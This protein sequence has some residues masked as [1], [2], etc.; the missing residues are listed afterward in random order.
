MPSLFLSIRE[1]WLTPWVLTVAS[2]IAAKLLLLPPSN[3]REFGSFHLV[4]IICPSEPTWAAAFI[5]GCALFVVGRVAI[6]VLPLRLWNIL[7]AWTGIALQV[8]LWGLFSLAAVIGDPDSLMAWAAVVFTGG[9]A[10]H[11]LR[12]GGLG[13]G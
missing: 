12:F 5:A 2:M 4:E 8:F 11:M 13:R 9:S 10:V 3:F 6:A 1:I 7:L